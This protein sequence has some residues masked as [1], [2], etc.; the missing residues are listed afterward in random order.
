MKY[1]VVV[2]LC[3]FL[4]ASL[5]AVRNWE[6]YT[7]TTHIFDVAELDGRL[8]L[9]T[10]GGLVEFDPS[11]GAFLQTYTN[12][13]GLISQDVRSVATLPLT[14]ELFAGTS[15]M[16]I[17][18][19]VNGEFQVPLTTIT[20]LADDRIRDI[21]VYDSLLF[22]ATATGVSVFTSSS[23][24]P[25]PLFI[26]TFAAGDGPSVDEM[27]S[28]GVTGFRYLVC[29]HPAGID[30]VHVD[31]IL[32]ASSWHNVQMAD[33]APELS[34]AVLSQMHVRRNCVALA[35]NMGAV[36]L[37]GFPATLSYR[38]YDAQNMLEADTVFPVYLDH[39][40]DLWLSYGAWNN[41]GLQLDSPDSLAAV[42]RIDLQ[43][44][45][46][47]TWSL[48]EGLTTTGVMGFFEHGG[49]T[50]VY[51]WGEGCF[52]L[53]EPTWIQYMPQSLSANTITAFAVDHDGR[54][55][56]ASGYLG[57][58]A[59]STGTRGVSSFDYE[60]S[61]W[62]NYRFGATP[63]HSD[64]INCL[65]V[66][67]ENRVWMGS[68]GA[69]S[70]EGWGGGVSIYDQQADSWRR[71]YSYN[72][73]LSNGVITTITT[74]M[75]EQAQDSPAMWVSCLGAGSGS[76]VV[77][78]MDAN[79]D[80]QFL[81]PWGDDDY[82][83]TV[84]IYMD[85]EVCLFGAYYD[86]VM[87][88]DEAGVTPVT[89]SPHWQHPPFSSL[90]SNGYINGI[91]RQEDDWS[92]EWWFAG[93]TGL[94]AWDG[95]DWF[96][97][98]IDIKRRIW[99]AEDQAWVDL[100]HDRGKYYVGEQKLFGG[101]ATTPTAML[102]DPFGRVWM[103]TESNG[104]CVYD[105]YT[106]RYSTYNT[107]N[108]PLLSNHVTALAYE[109]RSGRLYI[110]TPKGLSSVEVGRAEK[111]HNRLDNILAAPN[112]FRP[113]SGETFVI[114]NGEE[115]SMPIGD[116]QCRI[117][118]IAGELVLTLDEDRYYQFSWDGNN[119]VGRQCSSGI[120]FYVIYDGDGRTRR[121][122]VALIR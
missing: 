54:L 38:H 116:W 97:L 39:Q 31:S 65:A 57:T 51:T 101:E 1:R 103:G 75:R 44:D 19:L 79:A 68:Y 96:K 114:A 88:W 37:S 83:N 7:N 18:R 93:T 105:P 11:T 34:Q 78:G 60:T 118:D 91:V 113:D 42:V 25:F 84:S 98:D 112:P 33:I 58:P 53:E 22:V 72:S 94:Y 90:Y 66:D 117:Y 107:A 30:Y 89:D 45:E 4:A 29:Q 6:T 122:T 26:D 92:R 110:G 102:T 119:A 86:G 47:Q 43:Q 64:N 77:L 71:L 2:L 36:V 15:D 120:Y 52:R 109:P 20:G 121:G 24:F 108:A 23:D 48:E 95:T 115:G 17:S 55:W 14:G 85:D 87:L 9:A 82:Q 3:L 13:D 73:G 41:E 70:D 100:P 76:V 63:L 32:A 5:S 28:L 12:V 59:T 106:D 49:A 50:W 99:S 104:I 62:Q 81:V 8:W 16:G 74:D 40:G 111:W 46:V 69:N 27:T 80:D 67:A 61:T 21:A 56:A 10:W 35:T